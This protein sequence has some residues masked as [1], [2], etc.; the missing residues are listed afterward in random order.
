MKLKTFAVMVGGAEVLTLVTGRFLDMVL[1]AGTATVGY[2][3]G[4]KDGT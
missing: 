1:L 2:V 4:S 3:M